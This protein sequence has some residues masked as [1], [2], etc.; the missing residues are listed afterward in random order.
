MYEE[1]DR[2]EGK[3]EGGGEKG[4]GLA[5]FLCASVCF[6]PMCVEKGSPKG[7]MSG[8]GTIFTSDEILTSLA[9]L[10]LLSSSWGTW[11]DSTLDLCLTWLRL[12]FAPS[13]SC[14]I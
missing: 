12:L 4:E 3:K 11:V 7:G 14:V 2:K 13:H 9:L 8:E 6:R 5:L 10:L 1:K